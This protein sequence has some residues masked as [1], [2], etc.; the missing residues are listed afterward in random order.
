MRARCVLMVACLSILLPAGLAANVAV[1]TPMG[2]AAAARLLMQGTFGASLADIQAASMQT[3]STWF[4][5]QASLPVSLELPQVTT[6]NGDRKPAWWKNAVAGQDQLRQRVA[7]AL[8]EIFVVSNNNSILVDRSQSLASYYDLLATDA[9]GNFRTLID[10]VSHS[11]VMGNFLSFFRNEKP[12]PL[13]GVHADENYAREIMQLFTVGL[14]QLNADGSS[15]LDSSGNG[16]PTYVQVDVTNLAR[17]FT[18][19]ASN[20]QT[21]TGDQAWIYD[22]DLFHPMVAYED[23]HDTNA[24]VIIG[25]VQIPGGGT[26][27]ADMQIALDTLFNHPNVGPFIGRQL[28]QRL[29]TSNPSPDYVARVSAVFANN[30]QGVRGDLLA[31]VKAILTDPAAQ[32]AGYHGD[33]GKLR[34]PMLRFTNLWRAFAAHD[35]AGSIAELQVV[36]QGI[37]RFAE[38]PLQ[39]PTVFNFF[40]PDYE[41]AGPLASAG[42]AAP[43]FQIANENTVILTSN[44][45]QNLSYQY[46]DSTGKLYAGSDGYS[47]QTT[48][49]TV[50][51]QTAVW[52][53]LAA[54]A[55]TL[56][57]N[58]NLVFMAGQMP[59]AMRTTLVS[60]VNQLP[61]S[62]AATRVAEAT[63]LLINS[64]Q[65]AIQR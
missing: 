26:S 3:I 35:S 36:Q 48:P 34:E 65:Y 42:L 51:L 43:E 16:I 15:Q 11:P 12:N 57:D 52:E 39:S 62:P 30:G 50:Y 17:V 32:A 37:A 8:S 59:A 5:N 23:H 40:R 10:D 64:P 18:G 9:L 58:L 61:A 56:V 13:T 63:S 31:V 55:G 2:N 33:Q 54:D 6:S 14:W 7:F 20:P 28:I 21:H 38:N 4:T 46:V 29:V 19:W 45:L 41:R 25:G 27:A 60:Y 47:V 24:K 53:P 44:L 49:S 22:R 1:D